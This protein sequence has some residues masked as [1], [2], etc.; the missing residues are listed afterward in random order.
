MKKKPIASVE[1]LAKALLQAHKDVTQKPPA[2][3]N[4]KAEKKSRDS[5]GK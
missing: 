5:A 3:I 2:L 1:L 4:G